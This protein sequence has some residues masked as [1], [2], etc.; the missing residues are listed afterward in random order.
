MTDLVIKTLSSTDKSRW[1]SFV[2]E[3]PDATFF[4][5]AGWQRVIEHAFGHRTWFYFAEI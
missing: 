4:H 3:N 1:D 2:L 5:R